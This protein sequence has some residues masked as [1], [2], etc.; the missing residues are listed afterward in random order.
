MPWFGPG[1][2]IRH[3][4]PLIR[5]RRPLPA[6]AHGAGFSFSTVA[7]MSE[8]QDLNVCISKS[9]RWY[10][11]IIHTSLVIY[12]HHYLNSD[13]ISQPYLVYHTLWKKLQKQLW[14]RFRLLFDVEHHAL[15]QNFHSVPIGLSKPM[16]CKKAGVLRF[17]GPILFTFLQEIFYNPP[18]TSI[19]SPV[20]SRL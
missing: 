18:R 4:V 8:R 6:W 17:K 9:P 3:S 10:T 20:F 19:L 15:E 14:K 11:Y 2:P 12:A 1:H 5:Q 7:I 16:A 13:S